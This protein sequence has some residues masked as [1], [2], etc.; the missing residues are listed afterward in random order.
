MN[1]IVLKRRN[2]TPASKPA[3]ALLRALVTGVVVM[4]TLLLGAAPAHAHAELVSSTPKDGA[5]L[6]EAP[7]A[8]V[9]EFSEEIDADSTEIAVTKSGESEP[10]PGAEMKVE[11]REL[12]VPVQFPEAGDYTAAYRLVSKDGHPVEGSIEFSVGAASEQSSEV[13]VPPSPTADG[14]QD[15][16]S[17][18]GMGWAPII[19]IVLFV[20]ALIA[21][22]IFF[23]RA[24][25][26]SE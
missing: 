15:A 26:S 23:M 2:A 20:L 24:R 4:L 6:D 3:T 19:A 9:L 12:T 22:I 13:S 5:T 18:S 16:Q 7:N 11:D 8:I 14:Q 10:I 17:G 1:S 21:A 25:K